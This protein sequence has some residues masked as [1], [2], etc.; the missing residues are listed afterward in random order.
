MENA[1]PVS[2]D[3]V[4]QL[5]APFAVTEGLALAVSGGPDSTALLILV[6]EWRAR[7]A[8]PPLIL[9]L[10]VDHQLRA[11]STAEAAVVAKTAAQLG[12]AHRTLAWRAPKPTANLQAAAREARYHLLMDAA[13]QAGCDRLLTGHTLDDQAETFLLAL[14]R[15]SGVY[16]LAGMP[17]ERLLEPVS[18][19]SKRSERTRRDQ[20][21]DSGPSPCRSDVPIRSGNALGPLLLCRPFL[22]IS[23]ARLVAT[24]HAR[25]IKSIDD[26]SN[27]DPRF[28][29]V[30][31]RA[32]RDTLAQLGMTAERL[33]STATR[34]ARA[35]AAIDFAVDR[36]LGETAIIHSGGVLEIAAEALLADPEE[37]SLRALGRLLTAVGVEPYGPRL[38]RLE[39]LHVALRSCMTESGSDMARTLAGVRV[40]L[41]DGQIWLA[42]EIGRTGFA[43]LEL[44]PGESAV[45]DG[46]IRVSLAKVAPRSVIVAALGARGRGALNRASAKRESASVMPPRV[47]E[48]LP[49]AFV[50]GQLVAAPH[51]A[52]DP[53]FAGLFQV[54][55]LYPPRGIRNFVDSEDAE[56]PGLG[57]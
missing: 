53:A 21:L 35:A 22:S 15:G 32:V 36:M 17:A 43:T 40:E 6:S 29:R 33:A 1:E 3:E 14:A 49:G 46:R 51:R 39:R 34:L 9:V 48:V 30:Q 24:L 23:K 55:C 7:L 28:R 19:G 56:D 52:I 25:G 45:W 8:E 2:A 54:A 20:V 41:S 50:E 13:V 27:R 31:A 37:V 57:L 42:P 5:F 12:L 11:E 10:T 44:N 26:P 4:D 18:F 16:G 47:L 38:E